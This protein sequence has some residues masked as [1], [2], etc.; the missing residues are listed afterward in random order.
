MEDGAII[1]VRRHGNPS[2]PRLALSHGNGLAIDG[3][4]PFWNLLRDR[5]D[6]MVFDFRNHGQN[7]LHRLEDHTWPRFL[8]DMERLFVGI[9]Q[10]FGDKPIAGVFHSMSAVA[11]VMQSQRFGPRWQPLVL[12]DP[13]F[14]PAEAL[15]KE[16]GL[17][18]D[19]DSIAE[20]A[21]KR[22]PSFP[23]PQELA[24][25]FA[26][27]MTKW[28]P[29]AYELMARATLRQDAVS[30]EW[31][32]ACPREFEAFTFRS[33]RDPSTWER[34]GEVP[35]AV[36]LIGADPDDE[37]ATPPARLAR[38]AAGQF[39]LAYEAIPRTS[40]FLQ[41]ERPRE[42]VVAMETFLRAQRFID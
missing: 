31:V 30:R 40:H 35:V 19:A 27:R 41:I 5:Y 12:F 8:L 9:G 20:R 29:E 17:A 32:L 16:M 37:E 7:P 21:E 39:G 23:D 24:V 42:C 13:P 2:G 36:K 15:R 38:A 10:H 14:S 22:K 34:L 1:R 33:N 3:Y 28:M 11:A 18:S 4:F 26:R 25:S 6:L